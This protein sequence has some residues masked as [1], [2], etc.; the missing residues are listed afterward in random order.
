MRSFSLIVPCY[1]VGNYIGVFLQSVFENEYEKYEL[2]LVNDGSTDE[3]EHIIEEFFSKDVRGGVSQFRYKNASVIYV[4]Q[5][6]NGVSAARNTGLKYVHN[7]YIVFADPDDTISQIYFETLNDVLSEGEEDILIFGFQKIKVN[8]DGKIVEKKDRLPRNLYNCKSKAEIVDRYLPNILG[9]SKE[10]LAKS[11]KNGCLNPDF[12]WGAIWRCCYRSEMV[13]SNGIRF[14]TDI[15]LNEDSVFNF[16]CC[17][18]AE[19]LRCCNAILYNYYMRETGAL[20]QLKKTVAFSNKIRMTEERCN[21]ISSLQKQGYDITEEAV[22]GSCILS[23]IELM[24]KSRPLNIARMKSYISLPIVKNSI[25]NTPRTGKL[26]YD[27]L[28]IGL[29]MGLW[30]PMYL[31]LNILGKYIHI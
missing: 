30:K 2:I 22:Y 15:S 29:K 25:I 16:W 14:N 19:H 18:Y 13:L 17:V 31:V 24:I 4:Y 8:S 10:H 26:L 12:E 7:E 3:T 28:F 1:N 9:Y 21:V 5:N 11:K 20:D 27:I 23:V 6:N